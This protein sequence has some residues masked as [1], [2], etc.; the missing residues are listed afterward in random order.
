MRTMRNLL[1]IVTLAFAGTLFAQTLLPG[2]Q[3]DDHDG[4]TIYTCNA[5]LF[6]S[7]GHFVDC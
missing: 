1:L 6:D 3:I 2:I 5:D 4:E 7:G